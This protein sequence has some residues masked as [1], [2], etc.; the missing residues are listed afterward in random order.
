MQRMHAETKCGN[1]A[2]SEF[3]LNHVNLY[4]KCFTTFYSCNYLVL[5]FVLVN[6]VCKKQAPYTKKMEF[7]NKARN[8]EATI[9]VHYSEKD[10][11]V[12]VADPYLRQTQVLFQPAS[13]LD[14]Q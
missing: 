7:S 11:N 5:V 4:S 8:V 13:T 14:V 3:H 2:L 1:T 12:S 6:N 10:Y 9:L